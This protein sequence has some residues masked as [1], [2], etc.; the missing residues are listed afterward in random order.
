MIGYINYY[1]SGNATGATSSVPKLI[2][3]DRWALVVFTILFFAY[4]TGTLIWIYLV[5]WKKRRIMFEKDKQNRR[6]FASIA[7]TPKPAFINGL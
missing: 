2:V 4:Q 3:A 7:Q 1:Q 6:R 5:P